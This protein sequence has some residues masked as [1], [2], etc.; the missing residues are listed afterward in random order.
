[1]KFLELPFAI[2]DNIQV[3]WTLLLLIVRYTGALLTLP[4]IGRGPYG[5][6]ARYGAIVAF[7]FV[8]LSSGNY[9]VL[10]S[11]PA[12][13]VAQ[14]SS[15][16]FLGFALGLVPLLIISG[17]EAGLHLSGITMGLGGAQLFDPTS[18][19]NVSGLERLG[20]DIIIM[21]FLYLG[22]HH[23][24]IHALAGLN[25]IIIPGTYVIGENSVGMFIDRTAHIFEIGLQISAPVIVALLLTQYVMGVLSKLVPTINLLMISF[26]LTIGIGLAITMLSLPE[27]LNIASKEMTGIENMVFAVTKDTT[28]K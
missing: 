10:P 9:A 6:V 26:P 28:Q 1:M 12:L 19:T 14:A 5:L 11:D 23:I 2:F 3:L 15:E 24:I 27:I 8:S 4:G 17:I 7:S 20:G 25:G 21:L 18:N 13:M 22:G 16:F